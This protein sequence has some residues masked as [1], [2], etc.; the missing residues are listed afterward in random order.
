MGSIYDKGLDKNPAN[1]VPLSPLSFL[2]RSAMVYPN[3]I[4][5]IQDDTQYTWSQTYERVKRFAS[6]LVK[7]GVGKNDTVAC[8]LPNI[9]AMYEAHFAVPMAGAV[10][11][12][13]NTR[14]DADAIAF[15]LQHGEAKVVLTDPE[16]SSIIKGALALLPGKKPLV[17]DVMDPAYHEGERL[18]S[19]DYDEFLAQGNPDFEWSLPGD[20]WDPIALNYTSGTT[21]NPKGVVYHHR[22][23][24]LNAVSNVVSWGMA[25]HVVYLWTLPMFHCN[26]WCFPWTMAVNAGVSVCLRRVDPRRIFDLIIKHNITHM[27]GAPIVYGMLISAPEKYREGLKHKIFGLIAGAAPPAAILEGCDRMGFDLTHVY[28]LTETYGPASVCAK[29]PEWD[30]M[31]M[32]ERAAMNGRQGVNH[33][34][35]EEITVLDPE[36][37]KPVPWDGETVGEIMFRGNV[38]MKGYLKNPDATQ[39]SFEGG[40]FHTGDL[41]VVHKDG[42]VKIKD[43]SKDVIISGGENISSIE[44]EEVLFKHPA[45]SLAAVVAKPDPK[46][47]EV[48]CAYVELKADAKTTEEEII[49]YCKQH[50]ARFKVPKQIVFVELPKTSTGKIQKF[51][52]RE[53]AKSSSAIE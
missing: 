51:K 11:N 15:Q 37:M 35:Q 41:A 36:T 14:L 53:F 16:F 13:L 10:I 32:E 33:H 31:S 34:L 27:C 25:P 50:L 21:G 2:K 26:G 28:G 44:V 24:Y 30:A 38:V 52:L 22:G 40:W 7:H 3:R 8:M 47:G 6:A 19:I 42:Y 45:V 46:W 12:T 4:S 23:S 20:E 9:A 49:D 43:R 18:G 48:P 1:Y 39:E 5:I 29:H 17:I